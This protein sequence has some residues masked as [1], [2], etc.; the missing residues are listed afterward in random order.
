MEAPPP[1]AEAALE[2]RDVTAGYGAVAVLR[3]V[4]LRVDP[5]SIVT[6]LGANGAGK[7]TTMCVASGLLKPASGRVMLGGEDVTERTASQRSQ[8]GLCLIP[9]GR[10]I[11]RSLTV[12]ENLELQIP[13]GREGS[14]EPAVNAFPILGKRISQP[15][16]TLS[17]GGPPMRAGSPWVLCQPSVG[18]LVESTTGLAPLIVEGLFETMRALAATGVAMLIVEQYV[19]QALALADKAYVLKQGEIDYEGDPDRLNDGLLLAS[20]LGG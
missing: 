4:S 7:T 5:G 20:Y 16:G 19:S 9:E 8:R 13:P 18:R 15:A 14:I 1:E 17:G 12:K 10:G 6:L 3:G 11:F 2:L